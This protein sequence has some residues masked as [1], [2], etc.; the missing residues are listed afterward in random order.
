MP[1]VKKVISYKVIKN[2]HVTH[3]RT[4]KAANKKGHG[5]THH[6]RHHRKKHIV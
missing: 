6:V 1:K 4:K 5:T 2:G 3:H